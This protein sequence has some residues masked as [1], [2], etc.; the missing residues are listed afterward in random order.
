MRQRIAAVMLVAAM[1]TGFL[2][3]TGAICWGT[4]GKVC[5]PLAMV[6]TMVVVVGSGLIVKTTID[7]AEALWKAGGK[8]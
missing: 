2:G 4:G 7:V 8:R 5:Q 6:L 3:V 1:V